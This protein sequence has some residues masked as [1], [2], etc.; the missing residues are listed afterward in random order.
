MI[1]V[2]SLVVEGYHHFVIVQENGV[3]KSVNQHHTMGL[4]LYVQLAEAVAPE[5]HKFS[6]RLGL[7]QFLTG[8]LVFQFRFLSFS[9]SRRPFV[10]LVTPPCW[11]WRSRGFE[12]P[13]S[14]P[15]IAVHRAAD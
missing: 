3:D 5:A 4:L 2:P 9:S 6:A 8:N 7:R 14:F 1:A 11:I 10:D 13:C 15:V 12:W